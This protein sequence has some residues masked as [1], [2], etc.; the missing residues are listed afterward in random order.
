[1]DSVGDLS[2]E[3]GMVGAFYSSSSSFLSQVNTDNDSMASSGLPPSSQPSSSPGW[4]L[5]PAQQV[6]SQHS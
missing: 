1:M 5:T 3:E 4:S 6:P 2:C